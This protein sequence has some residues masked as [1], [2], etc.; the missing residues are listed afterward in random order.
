M[1]KRI[2]MVLTGNGKGKTTSA[3]GQ[4]V[5]YI[6]AKKKVL[7]VQFFKPGNSSEIKVLKNLG[8]KV[9]ADKKS[10]LPVDLKDEETLK[11]QF[12][13]L[14]KAI[15]IAENF[16]AIILDEFNLLASAKKTESHI[17]KSYLEGLLKKCDV[18]ATGRDAPLWLVR[19]ADTVSR[20]VE[21]KHHLRKGIYAEKGREY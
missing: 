13:L 3:V 17:L 15:S 21:V 16:D 4:S 19:M 6:G 12:A 18:V 8:V 10:S 7:L 5:R 9:I 11:R 2:L 1:E 14:K 20:I